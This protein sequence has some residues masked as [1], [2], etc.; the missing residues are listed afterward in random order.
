M[1]VAADKTH[2]QGILTTLDEKDNVKK[3][4]LFRKNACR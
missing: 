2:R 3:D 1:N 4:L